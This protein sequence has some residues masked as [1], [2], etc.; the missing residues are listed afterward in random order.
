MRLSRS[1][2]VNALCSET[3]LDRGEA[4][5][6]L[7]AFTDAIAE[8]LCSGEPVR[9][10]D[11]GSFWAGGRRTGGRC[12]RFRSSKRLKILVQEEAEVDPTIVS[13][14]R[15]IDSEREIEEGIALHRR[16][17]EGKIGER[18]DLGRLDLE[19]IDLFGASLHAAKL[20]GAGMSRADLGDADLREADLERADLT[21][22]SLAGANLEGANLRGACLRR[23]DLRWSDLR[24]ADLSNAI[25]EGA[26][27]REALLDGSTIGLRSA[28]VA[29]TQE[30]MKRPIP[31]PFIF[32]RLFSF[33]RS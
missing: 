11:F 4:R 8:A 22:A 19:A 17:Q 2:L 28:P 21:A 6:A 5:Q 7:A 12:A 20:T 23:A 10:R 1:D 16:W 13:L 15:Q 24:K 33:V 3:P 9:L 27:L 25:L 29:R 32:K 18:P 26:D 30:W 14:V 31:G